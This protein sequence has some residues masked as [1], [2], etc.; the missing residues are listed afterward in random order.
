MRLDQPIT[1]TPKA[2]TILRTWGFIAALVLLIFVA[3]EE[4]SRNR[5]AR[6]RSKPEARE[7]AI[8][9]QPETK[10][11]VA[12]TQ[13]KP[14][15][16]GSETRV[17]LL[18][19]ARFTLPDGG[20]SR[21]IVPVAVNELW[22]LTLAQQIGPRRLADFFDLVTTEKATALPDQT[23]VVVLQR[24]EYPNYT[25]LKIRP[26]EGELRGREVYTFPEF[27]P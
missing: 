8:P 22:G 20:I 4:L 3:A 2:R 11:A 23:P 27:V 6:A 19:G 26:L 1:V 15:P 16:A 13:A 18:R 17:V 10:P 14:L 21:P 7:G 25:L 24:L 9:Q 12:T 5:A